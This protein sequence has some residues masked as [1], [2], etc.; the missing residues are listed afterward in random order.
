MKRILPSPPGLIIAA[1]KS[2][3]GKTVITLGLLRHLCRSGTHV[4]SFKAG[5]DYIDPAFHRAASGRACINLD[6]W[7][8]RPATIR[9]LI[10]G[11]GSDAELII[12][13]G[14][15]GLFDGAAV[16]DGEDG[17]TAA[18]AAMTGWPVVL[19]MDVKGQGATAA[20]VLQGLARFRTDVAVTG[21]I[22]NRV[23]SQTHEILLR[24]ACA[25]ATP[26]I[27]V[28]GAIPADPALR[29][30]SRHLGLVQAREITGLDQSFERAADA[31]A[32]HVD[33]DQLCGLARPAS[34]KA[35]DERSDT[36]AVTLAPLGQRIAVAA[37]DA[38]AFAYPALLTSWR[39]AGAEVR[40]FSPLADEAPANDADAVYLP[41][42]YPELYGARIENNGGFLGGLRAAAAR[43]AVV[44][45]ECGGYMVLGRAITDEL[46]E[47]HDMAGLLPLEASFNQKRLHLG[48]REV[49]LA[50]DAGPLGAQG[51][52]FRG[53]EFHYARTVNEGPGESLFAAQ[54][55]AGERLGPAGMRQ[56]SVLGSFIHLIDRVDVRQSPSRG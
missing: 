37:D 15:M 11:L 40:P 50:A 30:Q 36:A 33:I 6:G 27:A 49:T 56:G 43:G 19:V 13:E 5:P 1:P 46:G 52:G 48:Y 20:A 21:V 14:V 42:G 9:R 16:A 2:A 29:L 34:F 55:A 3:S 8:M 17:S 18:L 38:F 54:N 28:L 32:R 25:R 4:A 22:F 23:G 31:I 47:T 45:G 12:G 7:A 26:E 41:G 24:D 35:A 39:E 10:A 53:H 44:F 51:T